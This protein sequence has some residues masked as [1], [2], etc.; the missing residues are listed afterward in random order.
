MKEIPM[1]MQSRTF[2]L[3]SL[4]IALVAITSVSR[5]D[6]VL[7]TDG[8]PGGNLAF[9]IF[10]GLVTQDS[11][12]LSSPSI[13]TAVTYG[14]WLPNGKENFPQLPPS[15][16]IAVDWAI[17]VSEGSSTLACSNCSGTA[18]LTPDGTFTVADPQINFNGVIQLFSLPDISLAPGTYWLA[19][20]NQINS[21]D[22]AAYWDSDGGPSGVWIIN[23]GGTDLSGKNCSPGPDG[24]CSSTFTIF[25]I[26]SE[27]PE[28]GSLILLSS[29]LI[30]L[31]VKVRRINEA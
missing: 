13:L 12:T 3:T 18:K 17:V 1:P 10:S 21:G 25:G 20:A 24:A 9:G 27:T 5:A 28:P 7:Y 6:S 16:G 30:L 11:F 29:S 2:Q 15:V 31:A 23:G 22:A 14:N 4:L 19:L 26:P 8:P